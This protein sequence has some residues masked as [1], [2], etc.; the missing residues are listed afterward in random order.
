MGAGKTTIG[1]RLAKG[2]RK[3]FID[4]DQ[5]LERRT[6]ASIALIFDVEGESG[7]RERERRIIDELTQLDDVVLATGG[8]A[9]LDCDSRTAL[10]TRGFVVY[11]HAALDKLV[12]RTRRDT[13]RPLLMTDDPIVRMR[14]LLDQREPFYRQVADLV[15]DTG[16]RNLTEVV[17]AIRD[18][19]G[20]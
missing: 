18:A 14:E 16:T 3:E 9:V 4:V 12:E 19:S 1:R 7:F 15:V 6:G 2:L 5:E 11:L 13:N 17:K 10:I 20:S 8:G